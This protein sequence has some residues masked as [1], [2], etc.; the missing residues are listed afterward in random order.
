MLVSKAYNIVADAA[1]TLVML[2][3]L[4]T[5]DESVQTEFYRE[6]E[7]FSRCYHDN[8]VKLLGISR[9]SL[10]VLAIYEYT[11]LVS[12]LFSEITAEIFSV[13]CTALSVE[14]CINIRLLR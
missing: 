5:A 13:S 14:T 6:L 10:P 9:E 8:V 12:C 3:S 7:L 2:K 11:D 4:L 1:E